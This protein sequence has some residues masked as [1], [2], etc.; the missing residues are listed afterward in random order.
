MENYKAPKTAYFKKKEVFDESVGRDFIDQANQVTR[1]GREFLVGLSHGQ[2][3][4]GAYQY[5]LNHFSEIEHPEL[6]HFT[7]VNSPLKRQRNLKE[8]LD[9]RNFIQALFKQKLITKKQLWGNTLDR[10]EIEE[11]TT[12]F[13]GILSRVLKKQKKE[14]LDYVFLASDPKGRIAA[15]SRNSTAFDSSDIAVVVRE[16]KE[17]EFTL[18]PHFLMKSARI[19]YLAT[20]SNKRRSLTWLFQKEAKADESPGFLRHIE[21][22]DQKVTV[23]IDDQALTWPQVKVV[24]KNI[25]G[26]SLIR[27]D[28]ANPYK[29]KAKRKLPVVLL[30][31]GFL[32]LNSYDGILT[33]LPSHK[34]IAAAMHYGSVPQDLPID[35]YSKHVVKNIE[36]VVKFFGSRG[37]TVF[38]FDHS[39]AN[40]YFLMINKDLVELPAIKKYVK[41]R[42]GSNPFFGKESKH[43]LIGF[44]DNVLL[45]SVKNAGDMTAWVLFGSLRRVIPFDT[46][47]GVRNRGIRLTRWLIN[48]DTNFRERIWTE[49]KVRILHLMSNLDGL[50]QLNSIPIK[51]ALDR[52]PAKLFAIQVNSALKESKSLDRQIGLTN[53]EKHQ[54]PVLILKSEKDPVARFVPHIYEGENIEIK[55]VTNFEAK[56]LFVEHLYHMAHPSWTV[57]I[58]DAFISKALDSE[59]Q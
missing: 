31:H 28:V 9:A 20:K 52:L 29:E 46:K 51:R 6:L 30:I 10:A 5:I 13:N 47:N 4:S 7:Y 38:L 18:T 56:D 32:G 33:S 25:H 44:M 55:D 57:E 23:F 26:E 2:S 43:A 59:K 27:I 12:K 39:I 24:R 50:P 35:Q 19:A 16:R 1:T 53:F 22:V 41:G 34:Y 45:P 15:I 58:I 48:R 11:Y 37:H 21:D 54:I 8:V 17:E 40:I 3:P 36:A 49:I 14:G 42:I